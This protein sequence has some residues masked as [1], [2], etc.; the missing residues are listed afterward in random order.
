MAMESDIRET[1][2]DE[3][4]SDFENRWTALLSYRY[5]GKESSWLDNAPE[6]T[7]MPLRHDMRNAAGGVMAAPLCIASPESGGMADDLFVPNPV[8][9]SMQILDD[10]R[11][12]AKVAVLSE[13]VHLGRTMGFSR[14]RVVDNENP[15][16][17]IALSTGMGI[18]LGSTPPGFEKVDNPPIDVV[19]SPSMPPLHRVF[20][21]KKRDD[22]S[23][24]LP[25]LQMEMASPDAALH[26]GPIHIV[27][28]TAANDLVAEHAGTDQVQIE[29]WQ[30]MFVARGKVGPFR[31]TGEAYD[32]GQGRIGVRLSLHD[33]G[34]KDR[35]TST[36]SGV[37]RRLD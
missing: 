14:S 3:Y 11:D 18:S 26:L 1:P 25:E 31:V 17:V 12:V 30:V 4:W 35:V 34:N 19:D 36:G 2:A 28:E 29:S 9:A 32:G 6:G 8:I 24:T 33:E 10:A 7:T 21:A 5:L 27:L 13:T 37:Y 15:D 23:W 20:G 16:R 22:G